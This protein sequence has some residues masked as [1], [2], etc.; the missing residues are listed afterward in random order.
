MTAALR[1]TVTELQIL[2]CM[3][4]RSAAGDAALTAFI[5]G[6]EIGD[7]DALESLLCQGWAALDPSVMHDGLTSLLVA[8]HSAR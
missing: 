6:M 1:Q 5:G 8:W 3:A 2:C 4:R 7:V